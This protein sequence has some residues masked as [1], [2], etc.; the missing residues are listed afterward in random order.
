MELLIKEGGL[1]FE[2]VCV[3]LENEGFQI[4]PNLTAKNIFHG[5]E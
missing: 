4:Q 1:V 3:D 2:Q 5:T